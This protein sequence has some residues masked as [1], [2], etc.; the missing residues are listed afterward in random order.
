MIL[1]PRRK[2]ERRSKMELMRDQL[3]SFDVALKSELYEEAKR[4]FCEIRL[5][6]DTGYYVLRSKSF[7]CFC[8]MYAEYEFLLMF[9][10]RYILQIHFYSSTLSLDLVLLKDDKIE[11]LK[12]EKLCV[13][14][15]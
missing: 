8:R 4:L 7:S 12:T 5:T 13:Q 1:R 15:L 10:R 6:Y 2:K 14:V 3:N 9:Y 11:L